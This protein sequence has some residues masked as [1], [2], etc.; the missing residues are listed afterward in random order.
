MLVVCPAGRDDAVE[1]RAT[2]G[3]PRLELKGFV[4]TVNGLEVV[5]TLEVGIM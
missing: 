1:D 4:E 2:V 3:L 5:E